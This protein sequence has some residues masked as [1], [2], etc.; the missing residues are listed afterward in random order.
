MTEK[1]NFQYVEIDAESLQILTEMNLE[2]PLGHKKVEL[3]KWA[4]EQKHQIAV[5]YKGWISAGIAH[6]DDR[7]SYWYFLLSV[8]GNN[9]SIELAREGYSINAD[10]RP[11]QQSEIKIYSRIP[12]RCG[13]SDEELKHAVFE[14]IRVIENGQQE[15]YKE[16]ERQRKL[17]NRKK[18]PGQIMYGA[19]SEK[20]KQCIDCVNEID[21][22]EQRFRTVCLKHFLEY[23]VAVQG[24]DKFYIHKD[25]DSYFIYDV[26][27]WMYLKLNKAG[28]VESF[29]KDYP[30]IT[31]EDYSYRHG[32]EQKFCI[33]GAIEFLK[34]HY[35]LD[36][37]IDKKIILDEETIRFSA[38]HEEEIIRRL[39]VNYEFDWS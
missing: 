35:L 36:R 37:F 32:W 39:K 15:E 6:T 31:N 24:Y 30:V 23:N 11:I 34:D 29:I 10:K 7:T 3:R 8:N 19:F 22:I 14:A 21:N 5:L 33:G 16:K 1:L 4:L 38:K 26:I 18:T 25:E 20:L 17:E 27:L 9:A 12:I 28:T 2:E 13:L